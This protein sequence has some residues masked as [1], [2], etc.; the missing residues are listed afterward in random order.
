MVVAQDD[1]DPW[2]RGAEA[3]DEGGWA[4]SGVTAGGDDETDD[5]GQARTGADGGEV[6]SGGSGGGK[7]DEWEEARRL[8]AKRQAK[9]VSAQYPLCSFCTRGRR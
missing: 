2:G 1:D 4:P 3:E 5:W 9:A 8:A 7:V 6:I